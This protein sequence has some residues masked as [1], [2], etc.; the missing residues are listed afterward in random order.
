MHGDDVASAGVSITTEVL[1]KTSEAI[2]ELIK[3]GIE[4]ERYANR[5]S[6]NQLKVLSGGEVTYRRLKEGGE[7]STLPN[8]PKE[9]YGEFLRRA[10][11]ADMCETVKQ[12][13]EWYH[14]LLLKEQNS[15]GGFGLAKNYCS[16]LIDTVYAIRTLLDIG[17]T[18]DLH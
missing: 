10:K 11:K 14:S 3:V 13:N 8:F 18:E 12:A 1:S 4:K 15:D 16:D 7:I 17:E 6:G 5:S 2:L 9:D